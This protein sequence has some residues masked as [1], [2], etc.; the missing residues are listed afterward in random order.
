VLRGGSQFSMV[1]PS[2]SILP[3]APKRLKAWWWWVKAE[4]VLR[5]Q[6]LPQTRWRLRSSRADWTPLKRLCA[7]PGRGQAG[8][9]PAK[10]ACKLSTVC[11][12]RT[13]SLRSPRLTWRRAFWGPMGWWCSLGRVRPW[14]PLPGWRGTEWPRLRR[15]NWPVP[16]Q[17][18][19]KRVWKDREGTF[20]LAPRWPLCFPT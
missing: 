5:P 13:F 15:T 11:G 10:R 12:R 9:W 4:V 17:R 7:R 14:A 1:R 3:K 16:S 18:V 2:A 20:H 19:W 6:W 8:V